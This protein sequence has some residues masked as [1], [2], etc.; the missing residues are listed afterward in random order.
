[1][2]LPREETS[3]WAY[4]GDGSSAG[5]S[6]GSSPRG[7]DSISGIGSP[8]QASSTPRQRQRHG[9]NAA[10]A[11]LH[12]RP[13]SGSAVSVPDA[14]TLR[15]TGRQPAAPQPASAPAAAAESI[16]AAWPWRFDDRPA[17]GG[18]R[19]TAGSGRLDGAAAACLQQELSLRTNAAPAEPVHSREAAGTEAVDPEMHGEDGSVPQAARVTSLELGTADSLAAPQQELSILQS[20]R[21]AEHI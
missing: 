1:M 11:D 17:V 9:A 2:C 14:M 4:L 6:P 18:S 13:L 5:G 16:L 15:W 19:D 3:S 21:V 20:R 12:A 10:A 8:R 7:G